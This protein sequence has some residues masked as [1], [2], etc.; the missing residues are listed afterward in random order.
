MLAGWSVCCSSCTQVLEAHTAGNSVVVFSVDINNIII[1]TII[2]RIMTLCMFVIWGWIT[3]VI[4]FPF[5]NGGEI[6]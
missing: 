1:Y 3:K 4:S 2:I 5:C 6:S